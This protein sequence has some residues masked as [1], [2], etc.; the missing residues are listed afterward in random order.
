MGLKGT[1]VL[2]PDPSQL[3]DFFTTGDDLRSQGAEAFLV[4]GFERLKSRLPE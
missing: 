3:G 1:A 2:L 4:M